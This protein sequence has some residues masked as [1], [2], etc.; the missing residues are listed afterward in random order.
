MK[1]D[2]VKQIVD[3]IT[4]GVKEAVVPQVTEAVLAK[5][6]EELPARKDV[7]GDKADAELR[8]QKETAADY[9]RKLSVGQDTKALSAGTSTSGSELVPTYVSSEVVRVAGKYGLT[10][11]FA[12]KWPMQG[13]NENVP[14]MDSVSA[15]RI[16]EGNKITSSQPTT[17][18]L[19]L[20]AKTIGVII[21]IS[22]KLLQNATIQV[23]DVL[24]VLIGEAIAKLEDQWAMLGL[25]ATE[26]VFQSVDVTG[27]TLGSG[28]TDYVDAVPEDLLDVLDKV[29][30][31]ISEDRLRWVLSRS[32]FN[33]FRKQ[34]AAVGADKQGFLFQG[35]GNTAPATMWDIPYSLSPVMP[36]TTEVSQAG[37]KFLALVD[38]GSIIHGD[39]Q[40]Y[41]LE[42]SEQA[43]IT[44]T[45]GSTL[46]NLFEQNMVALKVSGEID[47]QL[48]NPA[49]AFAWL[50]T[51]AS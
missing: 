43:T 24:N 27:V 41:T 39:N 32:V 46:I 11:Q 26:G 40:A 49:S 37:K 23:V 35:F 45:N 6:K 44:D 8:E 4:A 48:A 31:N 22:R 51:A 21:P 25:A 13:M 29:D 36:K 33:G 28:E 47:I 50:K 30:D 34:R 16:T 14:T 15:Y 42:M 19:A 10:R 9:L 5:M 17:G 20:R 1:N 7:F 3:D 2:E 38:F 18:S 12:R